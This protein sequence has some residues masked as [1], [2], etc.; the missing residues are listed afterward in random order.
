MM[1]AKMRGKMP[2]LFYRYYRPAIKTT[3][4]HAHTLRQWNNS[5]CAFLFVVKWLL[6]RMWSHL[7]N[8]C[9]FTYL[10]VFFFVRIPTIKR[11]S[12][13]WKS[14]CFDLPWFMSGCFVYFI[15]IFEYFSISYFF[16]TFSFFT[17]CVCSKEPF[18]MFFLIK[19]ICT[20]LLFDSKDVFFCLLQRI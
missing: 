19:K 5:V 9:A 10:A 1:S 14:G 3:H 12:S 15:G 7:A 2:L 11:S 8:Y 20:A 18:W 17:K 16:L 6:F 4:K 13:E